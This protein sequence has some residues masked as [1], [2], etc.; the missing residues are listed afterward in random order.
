VALPDT[1]EDW[2][3]YLTMLHERERSGLKELDREYEL[4]SPRAYMHPEIMR[5]LGDRLQQVVIAWPLLVVDSVEERLDVEGFRLP[6][7][8]AGDDDMWRV[9]QENSCDEESSSRT[10]TRWS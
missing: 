8:D 4:D 9:W 7:Q 3:A 5:E 6:S 10:S 2:V 1:D